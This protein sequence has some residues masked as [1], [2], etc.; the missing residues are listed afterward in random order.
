MLSKIHRLWS[1]YNFTIASG[2]LSEIVY[3][4]ASD[5]QYWNSDMGNQLVCDI[6]YVTYPANYIKQIEISEKNLQNCFRNNAWALRFCPRRGFK[7]KKTAKRVELIIWTTNNEYKFL[8]R[9]DV[10]KFLI[11]PKNMVP[12][13]KHIWSHKFL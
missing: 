7:L 13:L 5:W 11:L 9:S 4:F 6:R 10:L 8:V 12:D 1:I 2:C 3:R